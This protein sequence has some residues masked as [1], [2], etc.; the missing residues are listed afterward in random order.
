MKRVTGLVICNW[1]SSNRSARPLASIPVAVCTFAA[2]AAPSGSLGAGSPW[3]PAPG[4]GTVAVSFVS[5]SATEFFQA[6]DRVPTPGGG[7]DLKQQTVWVDGIYG[8]S[9][10]LA[11]DFRVG[12]ARS[13]YVENIGPPTRANLSGLADTSF[14]LTLRAVDEVISSGPTIAFRVGGIIRGTYEQ[15]FVNS[16]GDGGSGIELSTLIGKFIGERA[17]LSG[18]LGYR[19]RASSDHKIPP[20]IF[21]RGSFGVLVGGGL[22]VSL[23]YSMDNSTS[24]LN[25]GGPGFSPAV[26]PEL[27]EDAHL[28][29]PAA[30]FQLSNVASVAVSYGWVVAGR[31]TAISKALSVTF[32]YNI[33]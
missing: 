5:Q 24:G 2:L 29:G 10:A 6:T 7:H 23:N 14:G 3:L 4:G 1:K 30:S 17:G 18:E 33:D 22:G 19:Y 8:I 12:G 25:I 26:F 9:D 31:N 28:L 16:L 11:L 15:G 21:A 20:T 32:A 27:D 13:Q